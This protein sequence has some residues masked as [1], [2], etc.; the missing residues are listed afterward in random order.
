MRDKRPHV[1]HDA[2][3]QQAPANKLIVQQR[4][5]VR[6]RYGGGACDLLLSFSGIN[7]FAD[8]MTVA[9]GL[10]LHQRLAGQLLMFD[11]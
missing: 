8:R 6:K 9:S 11:Q 4:L 3:R 5:Q 7:S 2:R 10:A 1:G